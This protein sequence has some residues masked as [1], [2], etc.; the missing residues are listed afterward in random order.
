MVLSGV[1]KDHQLKKLLDPRRAV[2]VR[3]LAFDSK[4]CLVGCGSVLNDLPSGPSLDYIHVFGTNCE[5]V[6]GYVSIPVGMVGPLTLDG[7]SVHIPMATTE[8]C[9]MASTNRGCKAITQGS[10]VIS[11][12]LAPYADDGSNEDA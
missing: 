5:I 7:Q 12:I 3:R 2:D 9:L 4:I 11:V 6:V 8:G 10:G 1:V